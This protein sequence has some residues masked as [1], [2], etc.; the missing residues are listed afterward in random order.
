MADVYSIATSSSYQLNMLRGK[1]QPFQGDQQTHLVS[2]IAAMFK[3][4][5]NFSSL[6]A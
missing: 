4:L 3:T 6:G 2:A 1:H 5:E